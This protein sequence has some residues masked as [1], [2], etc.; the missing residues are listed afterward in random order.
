[1]TAPPPAS[2]MD[3][4]VVR[5]GDAY[6]VEAQVESPD[7]PLGS[8]RAPLGLPPDDPELQE[9][10]QRVLAGDTSRDLLQDLGERLFAAL[11]PGPV[12]DLLG[13]AWSVAQSKGVR[14]R[15]RLRVDPPEVAVLPWEFL[16]WPEQAL[17]M[18]SDEQLPLVRFLDPSLGFRIIQELEVSLPLRVL[19]LVPFGSGLDT[20]AERD[21]VESAL[22]LL[23]DR[24]HTTWLGE[25]G[26]GQWVTPGRVANALNDL[27]PHIV[28]FIG[29]GQFDPEE[30]QGWLFFNGEEGEE[31]ELRH[32]VLRDLFAGIPTLRLVVLNACEGGRLDSGQAFLGVAPH[33]M[34]AGIPA[35][36]AMQYR[37]RDDMAIVFARTF[38]QTLMQGTWAGHVDAAV[39]RAR[40]MLRVEDE[41]DPAFGTPVLFLRAHGGRIFQVAG[42][43]EVEAE[44]ARE[45]APP[46]SGPQLPPSEECAHLQNLLRRHQQNLRILEDQIAMFGPTPPVHLL[47]A[48][49]YEEQEIA[50]VQDRLRELGCPEE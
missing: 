37:V 26:D 18:A 33:I 2:N 46:P 7:V 16:Y 32:T 47:N 10:T 45:P 8:E 35:A 30:G 39:A 36:V 40:R 41:H 20:R 49:D 23:G 43:E 44:A 3:V 15:L 11:F 4:T 27:S 24:V 28:H 42:E 19:M 17:F 1:M 25:G 48:R 38:Y 13:R 9:L 50:R 31:R 5:L 22:A 6:S 29:H 12:G 14:L 34:R 21:A